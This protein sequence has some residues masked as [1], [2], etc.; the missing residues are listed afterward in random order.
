MG[1][2]VNCILVTKLGRFNNWVPCVS[3]SRNVQ[4]TTKQTLLDDVDVGNHR[5]TIGN[6]SLRS[7]SPFNHTREQRGAKRSGGKESG[8]EASRQWL[9]RRRLISPTLLRTSAWYDRRLRSIMGNKRAHQDRAT[10][11]SGT[12][13]TVRQNC[14]CHERTQHTPIS[15]ELLANPTSPWGQKYAFVVFCRSTIIIQNAGVFFNL[16][17]NAYSCYYNLHWRTM[18]IKIDSDWLY[19]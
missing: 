7:G 1:I 17:A 11:L 8:E 16:R 2:K 4:D 18:V 10:G 14:W 9:P 13:Q 3:S 6:G 15:Y 19:K 12:P 5:D